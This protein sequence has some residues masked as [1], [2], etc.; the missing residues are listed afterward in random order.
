[1]QIFSHVFYPCDNTKKVTK[2]TLYFN[3]E[4]ENMLT[5]VRWTARA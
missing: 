3:L 2:V 1:M 4:G 5:N